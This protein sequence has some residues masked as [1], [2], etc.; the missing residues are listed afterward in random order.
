M[1]IEI[2]FDFL[3]RYHSLVAYSSY[4]SILLIFLES[5][6]LHQLLFLSAQTQ[7]GRFLLFLSQIDKGLNLSLS[8]L[9]EW[10]L[11]TLISLNEIW[12]PI[13]IFHGFY[14]LFLCLSNLR[15]T[16][17]SDCWIVSSYCDNYVAHTL[18]HSLNHK[19]LVLP[20]ILPFNIFYNCKFQHNKDN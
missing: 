16:L 20:E 6:Y 17:I 18:F 9:E 13:M 12:T 4:L 10:N 11:L 5:S 7:Y 2:T 8:F 15:H 14:W 1:L 3:E 19:P